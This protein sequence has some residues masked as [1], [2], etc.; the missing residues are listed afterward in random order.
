MKH[1]PLGNRQAEQIE[2]LRN[3]LRE[4][5]FQRVQHEVWKRFSPKTPPINGDG[6]L[7][8]LALFSVFDELLGALRKA[9]KQQAREIEMASQPIPTS[10]PLWELLKDGVQWA[11][12]LNYRG[13][14]WEVEITRNGEPSQLGRFF[15]REKAEAWADN[16][17]V[18]IAMGWKK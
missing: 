10:G 16:E 5:T 13:Q 11:A 15:R 12:A 9:V 6:N 2:E 4:S 1:D 18:Q 14:Q 7:A 8:P 17:C 3:Q